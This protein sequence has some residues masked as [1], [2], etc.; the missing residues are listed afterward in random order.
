VKKNRAGQNALKRVAAQE[1][2][3]RRPIAESEGVG[4]GLRLA[5][6]P[7]LLV[8]SEWQEFPGWREV[9]NK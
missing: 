1:R 5:M 9:E 6:V 2:E 4:R 3:K 7:Q 8:S